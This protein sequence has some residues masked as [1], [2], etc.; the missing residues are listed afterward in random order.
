MTPDVLDVEPFLALGALLDYPRVRFGRLTLGGECEW[1]AAAESTPPLTRQER[2]H[3]LHQLLPRLLE[4]TAGGRIRMA[5]WRAVEALTPAPPRPLTTAA[6]EELAN[7]I[8]YYGDAGLLPV[9]VEA[10]SRLPDAVRAVLLGEVL[11]F[12]V[13]AQN[14]GWM[15]PARIMAQPGTEPATSLV[16]ISDCGTFGDT[17]HVMA[18]E[19]GHAWCAPPHTE[20]TR[21]P[22]CVDEGRVLAMARSERW[23]ALAEHE[24]RVDHDELL[25]EALA[26][27]WTGGA[28]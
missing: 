6:R 14:R 21:L 16:Q 1:R 24:R 13:G 23:P 17:L 11:V 27:V 5:A 8:L 4:A 10:F 12:G 15:G 25:A 20:F 2:F 19:L 26:W 3:A 7:R 9:V 22:R 28:P 18:H